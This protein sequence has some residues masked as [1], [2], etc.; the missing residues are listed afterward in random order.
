[1]TQ[2]PTPDPN[3]R[4]PNPAPGA[5]QN[6]PTIPTSD[7]RFPRR[8]FAHH[9]PHQPPFGPPTWP[10]EWRD[11]VLHKRRWVFRRFAFALL[12][13]I[14]LFACVIVGVALLWMGLPDETRPGLLET[15][16][17]FC[18]LPVAFC[19][20][21]LLIGGWTFRRYGQPLASV[22]AAA[23]A[24]AAGDLSVRLRENM[25]GEMGRLARSFNRMT[26][27]LS[28]SEQVRRNLTADVAHELRTPLHILQGN[29]EGILDGVYKPDPEHIRATLEEARLLNRLVEDLQT[30]SLAE[31]GQLPLHFIQVS[32]AELLADIVT[33]FTGQALAAGVS[34]EV[35]IHD[36]PEN[37]LLKVDPDRIDQV[38]TNL[39]ANALR[40]TP[41]GGQITL[42]AAPIETGVRIQIQ[43]SG[44]GIAPED[45]PFIFDRFWKSDRSRQRAASGSDPGAHSG[46]GLAIARQLVRA[47]GGSI[48]AESTPGQ[49]ARFIID[50]PR[51][52]QA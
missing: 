40:H 33:S 3:Q 21:L 15:V 4:P 24:V 27:E 10:P 12:V 1:M 31:A 49:G 35:D 46:L 36:H 30:L 39:V 16:L 11:A 8:G 48:H 42:S 23:D 19:L 13:L 9:P 51:E 7:W 38:L 18:G 32:A 34:L 28:R 50:L 14:G 52:R 26:G 43:D 6:H 17:I 29:L 37:L 41:A 44:Q 47:H 25:P 2:P 45:L 5:N 20:L 22:M